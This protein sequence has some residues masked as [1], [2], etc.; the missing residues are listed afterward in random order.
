VFRNKIVHQHISR[1]RSVPTSTSGLGVRNLFHG[2]RSS[3]IWHIFSL[4]L[5]RFLLCQQF[6]A[7]CRGKSRRW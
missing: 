4:I 3:K 2:P 1:Q 5:C 6:C 7:S